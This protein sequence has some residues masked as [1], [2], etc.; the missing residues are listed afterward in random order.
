MSAP[1]GEYNPES[2]NAV[3]SRIE[4]KIDNIVENMHS[5][6]REL[7]DF[8]KLMYQRV[9][10]LEHFKYYLMGL[11]CLA[12]IIGASIISCFKNK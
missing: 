7:G 4:T 2:Y 5:E 9:T 11:A 10:A 12:G 3:L 8:K 1:K 6:K